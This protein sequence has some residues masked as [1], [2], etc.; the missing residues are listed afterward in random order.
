MHDFELS[1]TSIN[2]FNDHYSIIERKMLLK[3]SPPLHF[4]RW[5]FTIWSQLGHAA[6]LLFK[7]GAFEPVRR[8]LSNAKHFKFL[9]TLTV[10]GGLTIPKRKH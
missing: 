5:I 7:L 9:I 6:L 8:L 4:H 2:R 3:K 10:S 1:K